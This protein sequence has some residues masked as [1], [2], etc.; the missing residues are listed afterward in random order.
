M[1]KTIING[2]QA[3]R[4]PFP[5]PQS[6]QPTPLGGPTT[7][8]DPRAIAS[9]P[10]VLTNESDQVNQFTRP[11]TAQYRTVAF[12]SK[13][14]PAP[15][16]ASASIAGPVAT[17]A[18]LTTVGKALPG[19]VAGSNVNPATL[20]NVADSATRKA[21][22]AAHSS[23]LPTTNPLT[24]QD[25]GGSTTINIGSFSMQVAGTLI[26]VNAGSISGLLFNQLYYIYYQD[27]SFLGN[28]VTFLASVTKANTLTSLGYFFVGSI[29]TANSGG[30]PTIGNGDGG[31]STNQAG[32]ANVKTVATESNNLL[33]PTGLIITTNTS[34]TLQATAAHSSVIQGFV[35]WIPTYNDLNSNS[36]VIQ[37]V[38]NFT[39][40]GV[41]AAGSFT[42]VYNDGVLS[43]TVQTGSTTQSGTKNFSLPNGINVAN[44]TIS[45]T[46]QYS[47][48]T[49]VQL[50]A[51]SLALLVS[52]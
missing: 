21:R 34:V 35:G 32:A 44:L 50:T 7:T 15:N 37:Y 4:V 5:K 22:E 18:S 16:A 39:L 48:G 41:G 33:G 20:A 17:N 1:A 49:S 13:A 43:G 25:A 46:V 52:S 9:M 24:S 14:A 2:K 26:D 31:S 28:S 38:Y 29:I 42:V 6:Q 40:T 51:S 3:T 8:L 47:S 23:Y 12:P 45:F 27:N 19:T 30:A 36:R 11:G 10:A